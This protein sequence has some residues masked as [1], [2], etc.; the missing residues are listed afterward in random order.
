M[1]KI[2]LITLTGIMLGQMSPGPSLFYVANVALLQGRQCAFL[3]ALGVACA[4]LVWGLIASFGFGVLLHLYPSS[5]ICMKL[6][7]GGYLF[8]LAL[9]SIRAAL[10][11]SEMLDNFTQGAWT[12]VTAFKHGF[13][14]NI[15]NP[16]AALVWSGIAGFLFSS[17]LTTLQVLSF[18]P[19]GFGSAVVVF[20]SYSLFFSTGIMRS[21]YKRFSRG[22]EVLFGILFCIIGGNLI[23]DGMQSLL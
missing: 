18:A 11:G 21:S 9:R 5:I 2:Y 15:T 6:L 10:N 7:C 16:K 3:A 20:G 12:P 8:Y 17:G 1:A 22:A 4:T 14:I 13:L 19:I 23:T